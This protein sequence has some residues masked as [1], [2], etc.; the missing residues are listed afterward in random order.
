MVYLF[1]REHLSVP[2][3][4]GLVEHPIA[5]AADG[6]KINGRPKKTIGSW[7]SKFYEA[8][9]D[10]SLYAEMFRF[11]ETNGSKTL[12]AYVNRVDHFSRASKSNDTSN[13]N[14]INGNGT[15][16]GEGQG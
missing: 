14:G 7:V 3:H 13:G 10:G 16:K 12:E 1:V 8:V 15:H 6:N 5:G 4:R 11:L 2:L 9:R